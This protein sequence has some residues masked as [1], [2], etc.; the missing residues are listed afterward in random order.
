V[1]E[2][3]AKAVKELREKTGAGMMDS[4]KALVEAGGDMEKAQELLRERGLAKAGKREGR[5][6]GEGAIGMALAGHVGALVELGC[7][8]DFVARNSEFQTLAGELAAAVASDPSIDSLEAL[9]AAKVGSESVE[10]K[11]KAAIGKLGEN[12]V[13]Q[14]LTRLEVAGDG[15]VGGYVHGPGSL[16]VIVGLATSASGEPVEILAKDLAMHVAAIDPSPVAVDRDG[17]PAEAV[18][19]ERDF[20]RKQAEQEGK[21]EQVVEKIVEGRVG[22]FFKEIVLLEQPFVK[23][24]DRT[25]KKLLADVGAQAGVEIR[26]TGFERFK[27]GESS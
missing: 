25:V 6:T 3:S 19:K 14:R 1:A 9:L 21:P 13:A 7:E 15:L 5:T 24:P 11:L 12:I 8:T 2:I 16:A 27:L 20:Y 17:V 18:G 4:K 10:Q 22:K 26:V 23:D